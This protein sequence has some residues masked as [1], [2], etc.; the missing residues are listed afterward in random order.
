MA[1]GSQY[2]NVAS[3][4]TGSGTIPYWHIKTN[5]YYNQNIMFVAR[6]H[7][8]AYG[9]SGHI[10]DMQRSGYAYG[11]SSTAV[12]ATQFVNNGSYSSATLD[13]YYTSAG[14]LCFR[15][16]AGAS[17]YYTGWAFDIKMQSPTGYDKDFVVDAHH[18]NNTSGNYYT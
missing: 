8:Y 4:H 14:Q 13:A 6:V 12:I 16:F 11:G 5:I 10:V 9:Q 1:G 3:T 7:G 17:S 15:A 2:L 18:M